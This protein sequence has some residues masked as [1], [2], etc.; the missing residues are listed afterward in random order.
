MTHDVVGTLEE[1]SKL[2]KRDVIFGFVKKVAVDAFNTD[3]FP[4][5]AS[6]LLIVPVVD[7]R[8]VMV[9]DTACIVEA[10]KREM[11]PVVD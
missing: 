4:V 5:V 1:L 2:D 10:F 8:V 3:T 7:C 9:P 6:K 11:F